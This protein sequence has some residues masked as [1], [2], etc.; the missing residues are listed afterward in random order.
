MI[1]IFTALIFCILA[2]DH[3]NNDKYA[4]GAIFLI[5]S[6]FLP[7]VL[8]KLYDHNMEV[9]ATTISSDTHR[10]GNGHHRVGNGYDRSETAERIIAKLDE[11]EAK[12]EDCLRLLQS[13]QLE[14]AQSQDVSEPTP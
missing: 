13:H 5:L 1:F 7:L 4:A 14:V 12:T 2:V 8:Q 10:G 6:A 3:I 9:T 11:L